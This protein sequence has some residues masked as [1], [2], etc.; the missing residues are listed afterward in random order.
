MTY[1]KCEKKE[2]EGVGVGYTNRIPHG[3]SDAGSALTQQASDT[4]AHF[5]FQNK[6]YYK[7]ST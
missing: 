5:F 2:E 1:R 7:V 3:I 4:S 6:N